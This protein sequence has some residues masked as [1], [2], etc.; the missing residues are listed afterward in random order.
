MPF[1]LGNHAQRIFMNL[2]QMLL[3]VG[4]LA[5]LS[6]LTLAINSSILQAYVVS[7]DSEATI[8][9]MSIG[10]SMLD[11]ILVSHFDSLTCTT[12]IV[13]V[14]SACTPASRLGADIDSE[15]TFASSIV[16]YPDTAPFKSQLKYNDIDDYNHYTRIVRSPHLGN[17]TVRDSVFYVQESNLD[18]YSGTQTWYKKILVTVS[19]PK[20]FQPL[21][22]QS[23]VV[24]RRYLGTG[25]G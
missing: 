8:D 14:P 24:F 3:V 13:L 12:Q 4:A 15:K 25:P 2:G 21:K 7:Y 11:E 16:S 9:A 17:F 5:I 22:L 23:L 6:M 19:H 20:L 10:Q 18:V 1:Y